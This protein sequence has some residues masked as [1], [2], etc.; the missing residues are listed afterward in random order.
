MTYARSFLARAITY[1][2][3]S[4]RHAYLIGWEIH[5]LFLANARGGCRNSAQ[6][7][8]SANQCCTLAGLP[9]LFSLGPGIA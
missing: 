3:R 4:M 1:R 7:A 5:R 2:F 6:Q 8:P 9:C